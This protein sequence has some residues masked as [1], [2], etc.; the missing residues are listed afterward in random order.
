MKVTQNKVAEEGEWRI[1]GPALL[2]SDLSNE[3][4]IEGLLL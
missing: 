4:L 2:L 1:I 3:D